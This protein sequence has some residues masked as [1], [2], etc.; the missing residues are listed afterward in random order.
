MVQPSSVLVPRFDVGNSAV[1]TSVYGP[2]QVKLRDELLDRAFVQTTFTPIAGY[3]GTP[4]ERLVERFLGEVAN[5]LILTHSFPRT[6]I[7][8]TCQA[9]SGDGSL[10]S[11]AVNAMILA[12]IDSGLPLKSSAAAV[13]CMIHNDGRLLLDPT[14]LELDSALSIHAF[15]FNTTSYEAISFHSSGLYTQEEVIWYSYSLMRVMSWLNW[16][17]SLFITSSK[18]QLLEK[19]KRNTE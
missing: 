6:L 14:Q 3:G 9:L 17:P 11:T 13:T 12:L 2:M 19:Y 8:I 15:V 10:L 1:L 7:R 5:E 16:P 18:Q 4:K